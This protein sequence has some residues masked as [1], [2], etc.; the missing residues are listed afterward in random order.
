MKKS[1]KKE[2]ANWLDPTT[3]EENERLPR[4]LKWV[5]TG[6][7]LAFSLNVVLMFQITYYCTDILSMPS[8]LVGTLLMASKVLDAFTDLIAGYI[9]DRTHTKL[10]KARPYDFFIPLLWIGTILLFSVP[11]FGV[12][13]KAVYIFILYALVNSVCATFLMASDPI[14]MKRTIRSDKNK[15][16]VTSFQ[17][18]FILIGSTIVGILIPQLIKTIGSEKSG[19][20]IIAVMFAVPLTIIGSIRMFTVREVITDEDISGKSKFSIG[21]GLKAFFKNRMII[22]LCLMALLNNAISAITQATVTYYAKWILSD[23]GMASLIS[24]PTLL[25]PIILIFTPAISQKIGTGKLIR[26]GFVMAVAGYAIRLIFGA[27][28]IAILVGS[29]LAAVGMIPIGTLLSI[30]EMECIDYGEWKTGVRVEGMITSGCGFATK[31][32]SAVGSGI[33]GVLMSAAGYV[34]SNTA[35]SQ[36]AS[37][38][39]MIKFLF[40]GIPLILTAVALIFAFFYAVDKVRPQMNADL[41]QRRKQEK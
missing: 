11:N 7:G 22:L 40:N 2:K 4:W 33:I 35:V 34:S 3:T 28:I 32:G 24:L 18:A 1:T 13:G 5:W 12:V 14:Y 9:I 17:G 16:S 20:T 26:I 21:E 36:S 8:A 25:T 37:A 6:R 10:G 30:Y 38:L 19:W 39:S 15:M 27:N 23:V 41:E 29:V 31:V